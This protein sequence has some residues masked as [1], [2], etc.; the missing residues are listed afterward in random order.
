M[1][2]NNIEDVLA[3]RFAAL[4]LSEKVLKDA[5]RN[6]K[7]AAAWAE[8]L[9]EAGIDGNKSVDN[10]KLAATLGTLVTA[11][12]KGDGDLGGKR[13]YVTKAILDGRIKTNVQVEAAIKHVKA[14]S[15]DIDD[16][17][18]DKDCGV[19]MICYRCS[20]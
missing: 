2:D 16:A 3:P 13:G 15:G 6:K 5:T 18:F 11:I 9:E 7:L 8:V 14:A 19:G 4:G 17:A 12:A 10:P 20:G 1:A